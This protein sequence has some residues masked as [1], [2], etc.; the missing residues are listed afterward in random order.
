[1]EVYEI[2]TAVNRVANDSPELLV[3]YTAPAESEH[4]SAQHDTASDERLGRVQSAARPARKRQP[5]AD[6]GQGS[7]F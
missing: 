6:S 1:M 4:R 3:P 5:M 2:S 7:L